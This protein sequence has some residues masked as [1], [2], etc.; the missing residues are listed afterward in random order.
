[1]KDT[2]FPVK[3]DTIYTGKGNESGYKFIMREDT[4]EILSCVTDSYKL[5]KNKDVVNK[6][7]K[8]FK[9]KKIKNDF[10]GSRQFSNGAKTTYT[11]NLTN[12][13]VE[14]NKGEEHYPQI[15]LVNSYNATTQLSF[16]A[17]VFRLVCSNGLVIGHTVGNKTNRHSIYNTELEKID[18]YVDK[19][20]D[21]IDKVFTKD[22]PTLVNTKYNNRHTNQF[23]KLFPDFIMGDLVKYLSSYNIQTYWDLLNAA[24]F[25]ATHR[26][27]K[28]YES[29]FKFE[30]SLYPKVVKWAKAEA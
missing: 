21:S 1:M 13:K 28:K 5:I 20:I 24:T 27:N 17:G 4:D 25:V 23:L 29:T 12:Q 22:F 3:E 6:V 8:I 16:L 11:W 7:L 26:M 14:T 10:V 9:K 18:E 30:E 19:T 15:I 2:F